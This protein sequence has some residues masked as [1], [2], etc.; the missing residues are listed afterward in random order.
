MKFG[1]IST[2][3]AEGKILAHNLPALNGHKAHRKGKRLESGDVKALRESGLASIYVVELEPGDVAENAAARRVAE[4]AAGPG[5][6]LKEASSGKVSLAAQC[7]GVLQV[8][9][10]RL[11]HINGCD[12]IAIATRHNHTVIEED[13][14]AATV[15]IIPYAIS[16]DA[17]LQTERAARGPSALVSVKE[18]KSRPVGFVYTGYPASNERLMRV[19]SPV[20]GKRIE[21]L[22]SNL[23]GQVFIPRVGDRDETDL[24]EAF[25]SQI[26]A[27]AE[28]ILLISETSTMDQH[29]LAPEAVRRAGGEVACIGAPVDPGNLVMIA[30]IGSVPVVGLPGCASS[31]RSNVTDLVLPALL[32]GIR[33]TRADIAEMGHAGLLGSEAG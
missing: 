13:Q 7:R 8:D 33:L 11:A 32:A 16:S 23:T 31:P 1:P 26:A 6:R 19:Y 21:S 28:L 29:D 12:G 4:A 2:E 24:A 27:G 14:I 3:Q 20:L 30:Y 22:G 5:L 15:K 17:L 18:L 25:V 9:I 10:P